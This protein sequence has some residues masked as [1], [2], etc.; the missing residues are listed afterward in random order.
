MPRKNKRAKTQEE[1]VRTAKEFRKARR[2]LRQ[3]EQMRKYA[4]YAGD[5]AS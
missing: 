5:N 4:A 2:Q 1:R 3:W